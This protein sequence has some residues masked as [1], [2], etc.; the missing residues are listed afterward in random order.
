M[1]DNRSHARSATL[2]G[3]ATNLLYDGSM[4]IVQRWY[5]GRWDCP[6]CASFKRKQWKENILR[7]GRYELE[8]R[9]EVD[10]C[11]IKTESVRL[12]LARERGDPRGYW[13]REISPEDYDK[14]YKQIQRAEV[15]YFAVASDGHISI[16]TTKPLSN[17][18]KFLGGK[19]LK[20]HLDCLLA[21]ES[22]PLNHHHKLRCSQV[23]SE[24]DRQQEGA[25]QVVTVAEDIKEVAQSFEQW[26]CKVSWKNGENE[27]F[28]GELTQQ[29]QQAM[30]GLFL[31]PSTP[32]DMKDRCPLSVLW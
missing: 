28:V 4:V 8:Y 13:Y 12:E 20:E 18:D 11:I 32:W 27:F 5:C 23:F 9:Q 15:R 31:A 1:K 6:R 2:C 29:A 22:K 24:H 21:Q 25:W 30:K 26:G 7:H 16:L 3:K 14:T 19:E 10:G 17:E